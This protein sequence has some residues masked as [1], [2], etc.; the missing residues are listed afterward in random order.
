MRDLPIDFL[1]EQGVGKQ[2]TPWTERG[3]AE[4]SKVAEHVEGKREQNS[5]G[6]DWS[7]GIQESMVERLSHEK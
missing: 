5:W 3:R 6:S 7:S 4:W 1:L 2:R